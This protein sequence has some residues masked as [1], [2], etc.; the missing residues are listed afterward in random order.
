MVVSID[1]MTPHSDFAVLDFFREILNLREEQSKLMNCERE[2]K[3]TAL[4]ENVR[5]LENFWDFF[6]QIELEQAMVRLQ[7]VGLENEEEIKFLKNEL[8][9]MQSEA[10]ENR[11]NA[12]DNKIKKIFPK[13]LHFFQKKR[14]VWLTNSV[15]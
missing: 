12:G 8:K 14:R 7:R 6:F 15:K 9:K 3:E 2:K 5:K 10:E 1:T 13:I 4:A 11:I